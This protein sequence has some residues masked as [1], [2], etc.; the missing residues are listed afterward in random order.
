VL[1]HSF[2][3][4]TLYCRLFIFIVQKGNLHTG[5][6]V[7]MYGNMPTEDV[8]DLEMNFKETIPPKIRR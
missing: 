5:D 8:G 1:L 3:T 4:L 2:L 6:E 7:D